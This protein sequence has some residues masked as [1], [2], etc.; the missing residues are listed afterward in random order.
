M[1]DRQG[2]ARGEA[3]LRDLVLED[4]VLGERPPDRL[5]GGELRLEP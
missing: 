4:A 3:D 5:Q 1:L 2:D